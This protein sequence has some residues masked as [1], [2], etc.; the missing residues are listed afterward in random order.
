MKNHTLYHSTVIAS[1]F[2]EL[3]A[4][5]EQNGI[6]PWHVEFDWGF[7]RLVIHIDNALF[8]EVF[9]NAQTMID[10]I[11]ITWKAHVG[12]LQFQS[13]TSHQQPLET[14]KKSTGINTSNLRD[15]A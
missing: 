6:T 7:N 12:Q 14:S 3:A 11:G 13:F 2:R 4:W 15:S 5:I 8:L 1:Q 10:S 9:P